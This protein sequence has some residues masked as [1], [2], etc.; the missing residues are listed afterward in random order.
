MMARAALPPVKRTLRARKAIR[1]VLS[2]AVMAIGISLAAIAAAPGLLL[3]G[4]GA[5]VWL[6]ADHIAGFLEPKG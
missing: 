2:K 1:R 3:L 5:G 4:I 6:L